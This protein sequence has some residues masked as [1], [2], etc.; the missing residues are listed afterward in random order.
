MPLD[1]TR[2]DLDGWMTV[3]ARGG[4]SKSLLYSN[5][6]E[7][8][9][10]ASEMVSYHNDHLRVSVSVSE[11]NEKTTSVEA[12]FPGFKDGDRD[13]SGNDGQ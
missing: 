7:P 9:F 5:D 11:S 8:H 2:Y 1:T 10:G 3:Q 13:S 6:S 12:I 4:G